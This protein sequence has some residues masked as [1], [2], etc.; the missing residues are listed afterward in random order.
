MAPVGIAACGSQPIRDLVAYP[1]GYWPLWMLLTGWAEEEHAGEATGAAG[2]T[3]G[4]GLLIRGFRVR[5]PGGVRALKCYLASDESS[6]T[7]GAEHVIDAGLL[8]D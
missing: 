5:V 7:T 2:R 8:A 6:Y 4:T 3:I 1:Q